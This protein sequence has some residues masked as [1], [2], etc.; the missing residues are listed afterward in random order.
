MTGVRT[1]GPVGVIVPLPICPFQ[2]MPQ[3][4]MLPS[5]FTA[6]LKYVRPPSFVT[7]VNGGTEFNP[8]CTG[9]A[10]SFVVP[11]PSSP[12]KLYPHDHNVPSDFTAMLCVSPPMMAVTELRKLMLPAPCTSTGT[13]DRPSVLESPIPSLP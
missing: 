10:A 5:D 4:Q 1:C 13:N 9:V 2:F 12:M 6:R 7:P 8:T 11:S 3:P